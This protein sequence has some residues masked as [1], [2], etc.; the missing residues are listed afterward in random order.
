MTGLGTVYTSN[1]KKNPPLFPQLGSFEQNC[2]ML[3]F[4]VFPALGQ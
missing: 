1:P 4:V 2:I 3:G